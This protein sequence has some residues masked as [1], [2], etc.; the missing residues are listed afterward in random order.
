MDRAPNRRGHAV[1]PRAEQRLSHKPGQWPGVLAQCILAGLIGL[2]VSAPT[3][4]EETTVDSARIDYSRAEYLSNC[5]GCHGPS[6]QGDG[7][8]RDYL[9]RVPADL[10][11]LSRNNGGVF[12]YQR[13]YE[14]IDGRSAMAAHGGRDMPIWGADYR[15]QAVTMA[16]PPYSPR[17]ETYVRHRIG[18]LLDYLYRI[19]KP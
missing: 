3:D 13:L 6:G 5:A 19:Q 9:T 4:A 7:H 11:V 8:F 18:L 12:P 2:L 10:T 14:V 1:L 17:P 15:A 16:G